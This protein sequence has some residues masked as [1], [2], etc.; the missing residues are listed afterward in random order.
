[1]ESNVKYTRIKQKIDSS[2]NWS[3]NNP[4]LLEGEIGIEKE[5]GKIKIGDGT[6]NWNQLNYKPGLG[7]KSRGESFNRNTTASGTNSHAEGEYTTASGSQS[8]AEGQYTVA[9]GTN[10]HAEGGHYISL[11]SL[12]SYRRI[13]YHDWI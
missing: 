10:S 12:F 6:T 1:M 3:K 7:N 2:S 5:T 13:F 8:H 9:S 11:W 4:I